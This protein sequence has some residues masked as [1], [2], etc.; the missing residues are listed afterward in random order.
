MFC[1]Y[2]F[3]AVCLCVCLPVY[4]CGCASTAIE[5]DTSSLRKTYVSNRRCCSRWRGLGTNIDVLLHFLCVLCFVKRLLKMSFFRVRAQCV[6]LCRSWKFCAPL[7]TNH[8]IVYI[9]PIMQCRTAADE[10]TGGPSDG[11]NAN[12]TKMPPSEALYRRPIFLFAI[13]AITMFVCI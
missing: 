4:L 12:R 11:L 1:Q 13:T 10:W 3:G 7:G 6:S 2:A 8:G 9:F 5:M